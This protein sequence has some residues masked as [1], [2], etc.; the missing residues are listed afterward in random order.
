MLFLLGR[1]SQIFNY[2]NISLGHEYFVYAYLPYQIL[3]WI[4]AQVLLAMAYLTIA[5]SLAVGGALIGLGTAK[6]TE[7]VLK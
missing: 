4:F 2:V 5:A 6:V 3:P 7:C 1:V